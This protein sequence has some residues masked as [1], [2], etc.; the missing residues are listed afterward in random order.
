MPPKPKITKNMILE[1]VL[2]ITRETGFETVNARSIADKLKCST[3][4]VFT[5]YKNMD[6]LK[7]PFLIL[8]LN[9]MNNILQL[10]GILYPQCP[11]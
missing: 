3:R 10:I 8:H 1:T 7:R 6:E 9:F 11:A 2:K 4:L 5:C